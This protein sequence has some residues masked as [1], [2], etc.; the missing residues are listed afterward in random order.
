MKKLIFIFAVI[1]VFALT[2]IVSYTQEE[3]SYKEFK[4]VEF[5]S[6]VVVRIK[7]DSAKG[8][9]LY[10]NKIRPYILDQLKEIFSP[11]LK[12]PYSLRMIVEDTS[13]ADRKR[14]GNLTFMIW[15]MG[16]GDSMPYYVEAKAGNQLHNFWERKVLKEGLR[17]EI[18]E[19]AK[20]LI[21]EFIQELANNFFAAREG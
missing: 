10:E 6:S 4:E 7:G 5:F 3:N 15:I 11:K 13:L 21:R 14:F 1:L 12:N 17:E 18:T 19:E 16:S 8:L 2:D 20:K 9:G